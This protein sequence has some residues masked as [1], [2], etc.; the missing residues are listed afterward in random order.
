MKDLFL[1][2]DI[3]SSSIRASLH[4]LDSS[5]V[6]G[7]T[8]RAPQHWQYDDGQEVLDP[9][10]LLNDVVKVIDEVLTLLP[11]QQQIVA[12]GVATLVG[13]LVGLD[14]QGQAL[15]PII[16]YADTRSHEAVKNLKDELGTSL[17]AIENQTGCPL[18]TAYWPAQLSHL[19]QTQP[20]TVAKV[21]QWCD[22]STLLYNHWFG[23]PQPLSYS[24]AS[25]SGLLDR[26]N[27]RWSP[28]LIKL[29]GLSLSRQLPEL[30]DANQTV[31]GLRS[32]WSQHWPVLKKAVF[33][34]S[35]GDGAAANLGSGGFDP[36]NLVI[37]IGSTSAARLSLAGTAV[38]PS[39]LWAYRIN[40][41]YSLVG[42]AL[43]EGGSSFAWLR[44]RLQLPAPTVL[45]QQLASLPPA[46]HGLTVLPFLKGERSPG[47]HSQASASI[48]G[49]R[50]ETNPAEIVQAW[51]E[52]IAYRLAEVVDRLPAS[53][54]VIASGGALLASAAW[55]QIL[56]DVLLKP[57]LL[58]TDTEVSSRGVAFYM[59][60]DLGMKPQISAW[61]KPVLPDDNRHR[62]YYAARLKQQCLYR[63]LYEKI[64]IT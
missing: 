54:R 57:V 10:T 52:A 24:V 30:V 41:S 13:S 46:A 26:H 45:E 27:L 17:E 53:S 5:P 4:R 23:Y 29:L 38:R 8:A 31:Q 19:A 28:E 22:L 42:G 35:L 55:Q 40:R 62:L 59:A 50:Q 48:L 6:P 14:A 1:V 44:N 2:L 49:L 12:V 32:P 58:V 18:H 51:L 61:D 34:R 33:Y 7:L 39:G 20:Q 37:T 16:S 15:T 43:S 56:A 3:G 21:A 63:L 25:W 60:H 11:P 36:E 9:T 64:N 47:W